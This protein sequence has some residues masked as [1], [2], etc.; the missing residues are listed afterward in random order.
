[1]NVTGW[2]KSTSS[3]GTA[4]AAVVPVI[5]SVAVGTV[6]VVTGVVGVTGAAV[7]MGVT[8]SGAS[9]RLRDGTVRPQPEAQ[10]LY[11]QANTMRTGANISYGVAGAA[12]VTAAILFF[13]EGQ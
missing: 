4:V 3:H 2:P 12:L 5:A 10:A 8:A 11:D 1:M 9:Q 6:V 7:G 13:V